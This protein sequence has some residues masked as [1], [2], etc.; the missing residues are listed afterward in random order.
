MVGASTQAPN[1]RPGEKTLTGWKLRAGAHRRDNGA[2]GV[3]DDERLLVGPL[4]EV[5]AAQCDDVCVVA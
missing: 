2:H 4:N 5:I 1:M 3:N